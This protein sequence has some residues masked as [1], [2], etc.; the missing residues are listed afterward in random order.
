[1][2]ENKKEDGINSYL[3][4]RISRR[5]AMRAGGLAA[6]GLAFSKPIINT[7]RPQPAYAQVSVISTTRFKCI[8]T[9]EQNGS[10]VKTYDYVADRDY[11]G[12]LDVLGYTIT[13]K[14]Y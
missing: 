3:K 10:V 7:I 6:L 5:Q 1:M 9:V 12:T 11:S 2:A 8:V 13:T 14:C 4:K